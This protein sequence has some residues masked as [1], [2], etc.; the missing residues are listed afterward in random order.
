MLLL[1][2][3]G[4]ASSGSL[5]LDLKEVD[6]TFDQFIAHAQV[7]QVSTMAIISSLLTIGHYV[8]GIS[9]KH[10]LLTDASNCTNLLTGVNMT[11]NTAPI[12]PSHVATNP[13]LKLSVESSSNKKGNHK[14]IGSLPAQSKPVL[15]GIGGGSGSDLLTGQTGGQGNGIAEGGHYFFPIN[16]MTTVKFC[17]GCMHS[18]W[19]DLNN[20]RCAK[21]LMYAHLWC[22]KQTAAGNICENLDQPGSLHQVGPLPSG[23]TLRGSMSTREPIRNKN[24]RA[25]SDKKTSVIEMITGKAFQRPSTADVTASSNLARSTSSLSDSSSFDSTTSSSSSDID[26]DLSSGVNTFNYGLLDDSNDT[27]NGGSC[28]S[29]VSNLT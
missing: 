2:G 7:G 6:S 25:K 9:S 3:P 19:G 23:V 18:L 29:G 24:K 8:F 15:N 13:V 12:V 4:A 11:P 1:G 5:K 16:E 27:L 26:D 28:K 14:R 21:C 17:N 10:L 20:Y 22:L